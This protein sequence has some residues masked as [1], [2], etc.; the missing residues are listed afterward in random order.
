[1]KTFKAK[2]RETGEV[3]EVMYNPE[4]NFYE[5]DAAV[6]NEAW[7]NQYYERIDR[8]GGAGGRG[9][10]AGP[11]SMWPRECQKCG[12]TTESATQ[13]ELQMERMDE[14]RA[15]SVAGEVEE[16]SPLLKFEISCLRGLDTTRK[17][18]IKEKLIEYISTIKA[19]VGGQRFRTT[20]DSHHR[21]YNHALDDILSILDKYID[22]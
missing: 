16:V 7:F 4:S 13:P 12:A 2:H 20:N 15:A 14:K 10:L 18:L 19:E 6:A 11:H 8:P 3:V 22:V 17:I 1:M 5:L 9:M 21:S